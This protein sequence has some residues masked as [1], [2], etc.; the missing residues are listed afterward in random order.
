VAAHFARITT[1]PDGV[2][3]CGRFVLNVLGI[4]GWRR[5]AVAGANSASTAGSEQHAARGATG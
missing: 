3:M 5:K 2:E 4:I 1:G